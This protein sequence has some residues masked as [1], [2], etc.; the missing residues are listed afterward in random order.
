MEKGHGRRRRAQ[1]GATGV[2]IPGPCALAT[3]ELR[4]YL[5]YNR[6][7]LVDYGRRR[8]NGKAVSTSRAEGSAKVNSEQ[9]DP[10]VF[11]TP[12]PGLD[13]GHPAS[14]LQTRSINSFTG[15]P[16]SAWRSVPAARL[17]RGRNKRPECGAS[18]SYLNLRFR[19]ARDSDPGG[20]SPARSVALKPVRGRGDIERSKVVAS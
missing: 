10:Q 20:I 13:G 7:A 1:R 18:L 17:V 3:M 14:Q 5:E 8:R 4:T 6:A 15:R 11:S 19:K 16:H 9:L 12:V 2:E